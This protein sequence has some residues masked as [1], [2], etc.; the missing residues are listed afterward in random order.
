MDAFCAAV[1]DLLGPLRLGEPTWSP[2]AIGADLLG[3]GARRALFALAGRLSDRVGH[4]ARGARPGVGMYRDPDLHAAAGVVGM[5]GLFSVVISGR[6]SR[7]RR[8]RLPARTRAARTRRVS[9]TASSNG[10]GT[11]W[12]RGLVIGRPAA[13]PWRD[14]V[15]DLGLR[16]RGPR[17]DRTARS[18]SRAAGRRPWRSRS[19][20][21]SY[22]L[23]ILREVCVPCRWHSVRVSASVS[24]EPLTEVRSMNLKPLGDRV[25]RR[26][27]R[28]GADHGE[29]HRPSRHREGEAAAR[30]RPRRRQGPVRGRQ[31]DPARRRG[32]RRDHLLEVRRHRGQG[33]GRGLPDPARVRR[34]RQARPRRRPA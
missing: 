21:A 34:A 27:P 17:R 22:P 15:G 8:R 2:Q 9:A 16:L 11:G 29:R 12:A 24:V 18:W 20:S 6:C 1:V 5:L 3:V 26:G 31:A 30:P 28:G 13:A 10:I 14:A 7:S 19:K 4:G 32:R 23:D 33:R 25:D